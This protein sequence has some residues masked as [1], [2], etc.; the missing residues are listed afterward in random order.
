MLERLLTK[1]QL[2]P[3]NFNSLDHWHQ[4]LLVGAQPTFQTTPPGL[5]ATFP[6][7]HRADPAM[8]AVKLVRM[9]IGTGANPSKVLLHAIHFYFYL[10]NFQGLPARCPGQPCQT[11]LQE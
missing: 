5:T 9:A 8:C 6:N 4:K 1:R 7:P 3:A 11:A 10:L 2:Q